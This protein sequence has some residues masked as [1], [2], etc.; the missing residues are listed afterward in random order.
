MSAICKLFSY[1]QLPVRISFAPA[2]TGHHPATINA[3]GLTDCN[4]S[5]IYEIKYQ[6]FLSILTVL[7]STQKS[8]KKGFELRSATAIA[9]AI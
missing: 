5:H 6:S 3:G 7:L 1:W 8:S 9:V 2:I 4:R